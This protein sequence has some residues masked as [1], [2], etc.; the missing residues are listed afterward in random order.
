M[1]A[2]V[3]AA[4]NRPSLFRRAALN[5]RSLK[6]KSRWGDILSPFCATSREQVR[7]RLH[8]QW[9]KIPFAYPHRKAEVPY[10][11]FRRS[12]IT[13]VFS[14]TDCE[15]LM[16]PTPAGCLPYFERRIST[17]YFSYLSV[18]GDDAIWGS[19]PNY[20]IANMW[21]FTA[22]SRT[23]LDGTVRLRRSMGSTA[24]TM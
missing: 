10:P 11:C 17:G 7:D 6:W 18:G 13:S 14:T 8:K 1:T 15:S 19:N 4:N 2:G 16:T 24:T 23:S 5:M 20:P 12:G 3:A 22:S 21:L 9:V